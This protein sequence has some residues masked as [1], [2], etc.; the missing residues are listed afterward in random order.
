MIEHLGLIVQVVL[1]FIFGTYPF[2]I[3]IS[4]LYLGYLATLITFNVLWYKDVL[5]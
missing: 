4:I 1:T 5:K 2:A 3:V